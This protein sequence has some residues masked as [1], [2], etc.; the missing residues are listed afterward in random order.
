MQLLSW[1]NLLRKPRDVNEK[2]TPQQR[3][4]S[5]WSPAGVSVNANSALKISAVYSAIDLISSNCAKIPCN[6]Y[7]NNGD[8]RKK[9]SDDQRHRLVWREPEPGI[10]AFSFWKTI[11][12]WAVLRGNGYAYINRVGSRPAELWLIPPEF[13]MPTRRDGSIFYLIKLDNKTTAAVPYYDM[14]HIKGMGYDGLVGYSTIEYFATDGGLAQAMRDYASEFFANGAVPNLIISPTLGRLN[15]SEYELFRGSWGEGFSG[16]GN[17]HKS[18][19]S[20]E[21]LN[22]QQLTINARDAQLIEGRQMS[23]RDIASFWHVPPHKLGD[24]SR[25]AYNSI[26]AENMN[27]LSDGLDPWLVAAEQELNCKLL[28]E[29]E[30]RDNSYFFEFNRAA[31]V[32]AD[33]GTRYTAMQKAVGRAWMTPNEARKLENMNAVDGGDELLTPLN[34]GVTTNQNVGDSQDGK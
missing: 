1:M 30:K 5:F 16:K 24:N 33:L 21:P 8:E 9:A 12:S 14:L 32:R 11:I 28:T 15:K 18:A 17:R 23:I 29:Q 7:E 3:T 22:A 26:E 34:Q 20:P 4:P 31:F 25:M 19:V 27:F 2:E 6:L 13:C 10:T